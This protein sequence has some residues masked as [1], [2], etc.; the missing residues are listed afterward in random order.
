MLT[1]ANVIAAIEARKLALAQQYEINRHGVVRELLASVDVA[2]GKL[3]AGS[4][5]RAWTEIAKILGV[6][7]PE[8]VKE[9]VY[10]ENEVLEAKF[11]V[12]SDYELM[13]IA[14][15]HTLPQASI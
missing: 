5:I 13:A 3:D 11:A 15:G 6:Y 10:A 8:P 7:S 2:R 4:M 14:G 9:V 12:M 1:D